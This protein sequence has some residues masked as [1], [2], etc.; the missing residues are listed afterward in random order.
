VT[1]ASLRRRLQDAEQAFR[2]RRMPL[3][4]ADEA[5]LARAAELQRINP[6]WT[7]EQCLLQAIEESI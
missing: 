1:A 3:S 5:A 2:P 7:L 6:A 4:A